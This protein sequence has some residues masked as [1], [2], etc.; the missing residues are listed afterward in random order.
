V[1]LQSGHTTARL[2]VMRPQVLATS[3]SEA[4]T[5]APALLSLSFATVRQHRVTRHYCQS[6]PSLLE[7]GRHSAPA[8]A[9]VRK[10]RTTRSDVTA[11]PYFSVDSRVVLCHKTAADAVCAGDRGIRVPNGASP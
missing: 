11:A 4:A 10:D 5:D 9:N 2:P 1:P 3:R 8:F 7:H 6:S